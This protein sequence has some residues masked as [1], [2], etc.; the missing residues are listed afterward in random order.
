MKKEPTLY[1]LLGTAFFGAGAYGIF[2]VP[3]VWPVMLLFLGCALFAFPV[4]LPA[5]GRREIFSA[6]IL[7]RERIADEP[8]LTARLFLA[9]SWIAR[10]EGILALERII[11]SNVCDHPTLRIGL[12]MAIDGYDPEFTGETLRS[13]HSNFREWCYTRCHDLRQFGAFLLFVGGFG[14]ASGALFHAMRYWSGQA[15][16]VES[17]CLTAA[18]SFLFLMPGLAA[19]LLLPRR[20]LGECR[21]EQTLQRQIISGVLGL[22]QGNSPAAFVMQQIMFLPKDRR[23]AL[24]RMPLPETLRDSEM[25]GER[26]EQALD[27]IRGSIRSVAEAS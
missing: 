24:M 5:A 8:L 25:K 22:Q 18:L 27:D 7:W 12:T 1:W 23:E 19:S 16:S 9:M 6:P 15:V 11:S 2:R 20:I 21:H 17:V 4:G 14:G 10:H 26:F 13:A 3:A